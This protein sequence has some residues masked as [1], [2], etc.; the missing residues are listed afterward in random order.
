MVTSNPGPQ[1]HLE[2]KSA[3]LPLHPTCPVTG[4]GDQL[5]CWPPHPFLVVIGTYV[6]EYAYTHS[7]RNTHTKTHTG[8]H[9]LVLA[10]TQT[11]T[12]IHTPYASLGLGNYFIGVSK[13]KLSLLHG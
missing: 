2:G 3:Y 10:H 11:R 8:S 7:H 6:G 9:T 12:R 1:S 13:V 4:E 5:S